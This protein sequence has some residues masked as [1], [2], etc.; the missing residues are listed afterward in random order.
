MDSAAPILSLSA[1]AKD[2]IHGSLSVAALK[3]VNLELRRGEFVGLSGPSGS[4][5]STL[6]NI[7]GLTDSPTSGQL[8]FEGHAVNFA[9]EREVLVLR[10]SKI[11]YVFQYFNLIPSLTAV[12]NVALSRLLNGDSY[13]QA[14]DA[15]AEVL[16]QAGLGG[17]LNHR[18]QELSGGEMQ[19]VAF[20]RA[21]LHRP[22]LLLADEPTGNLDSH[23]GASVLFLLE[24]LAAGG[25][26][27]LM[28]SHN[29]DALARCSRQIRLLDG[30][31][32]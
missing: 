31:L 9:D 10:R 3:G 21:I 22:V 2:Y 19:R 15:A 23:T 6:L 7:V 14:A 18:P 30:T 29:Q 4:G 27:I 1:I 12:E 24:N 17:R 13:Q 11:G 25:T 28:A 16:R 26:A 20:C 5:K 32:S 8:H